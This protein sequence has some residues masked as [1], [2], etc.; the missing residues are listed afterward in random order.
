[1]R[2]QG[3]ETTLN[4]QCHALSQFSKVQGLSRSPV[5]GVKRNEKPPRPARPPSWQQRPSLIDACGEE[6]IMTRGGKGRRT[7]HENSF[8]LAIDLIG[9]KDRL[10]G[11]SGTLTR[12]LLFLI[13]YRVQ[14]ITEVIEAQGLR[15]PINSKMDHNITA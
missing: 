2:T 14:L 13:Y 15:I 1:M 12:P 8:L 7:S 10:D 11:G 9:D 6:Y 5:G 3:S 4:K